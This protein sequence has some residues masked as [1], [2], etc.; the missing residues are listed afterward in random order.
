MST[1][2]MRCIMCGLSIMA[3]TECKRECAKE[4]CDCPCNM[5]KSSP[6]PAPP[7][8]ADIARELFGTR[9]LI[10]ATSP[11]K[12][13]PGQRCMPCYSRETV[14]AA[15]ARVAADAAADEREA[16]LRFIGEECYRFQHQD[17]ERFIRA[18]AKGG[19]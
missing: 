2:D 9:C 16:I 11:S 14:A 15:L 17:V 6:N 13:G 7:N 3:G 5:S 18:R 12:C 19:A 4:G 8:Y 10:E 1:K